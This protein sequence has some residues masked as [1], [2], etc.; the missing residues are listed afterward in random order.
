MFAML[1]EAEWR[2]LFNFASGLL[3]LHKGLAA[4]LTL[5]SEL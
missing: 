4:C 2:L 1:G 5:D 3:A